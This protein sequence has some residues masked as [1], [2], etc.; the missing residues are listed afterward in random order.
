M[1][2][3]VCGDFAPRSTLRLETRPVP[4]PGAGEV[5]IRVAAC[6]INFFDGLMVEGKYQTKPDRPFTP[7]AEVAGVVERVGEDVTSL[8]PGDRV[9]ACNGIGGYAEYAVAPQERCCPI[10]DAMGFAEAAGFLITHATSHHA[11]KDGADLRPGE[12]LLVLGAAGGVGLTAVEI[13]RRMGARVIA[14]ASTEEKLALCRDH[15]AQETI[16]Y[17]TEDLRARL[18]ELTGGRGVD[19]VYDPVGGPMAET[20]LR[21][22]ATDGRYLVIGFASGEIPKIP[23]NLLLLKQSSMTG[24]FWGAFARANPD[25]HAANMAELFRWFEEGSLHPHISAEY[26]LERFAEALD[27]VMERKVKGKVVLTM[28]AGAEQ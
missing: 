19:V 9:L 26:P 1:K 8:R 18:K 17:A 25:R 27:A 11:L 24:V 15:G 13:G 21:G 28:G 12:V 14:A 2:A 16:N 7:G 6:G 4:A 20:A 23:L 22:L 10:P 5:L 3:V